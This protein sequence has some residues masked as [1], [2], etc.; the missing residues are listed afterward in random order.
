[1]S[2]QVV[3]RIIIGNVFATER[4]IQFAARMDSEADAIPPW[5]IL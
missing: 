2:E 1:M 4:S 3:E 5:N